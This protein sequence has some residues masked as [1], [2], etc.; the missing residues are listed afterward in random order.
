MFEGQPM[1]VIL[2]ATLLPFKDEIITD[3]LINGS[4]VTVGPGI[5]QEL[6]DTYMN[7]KNAG[8]IKKTLG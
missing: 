7:A 5:R 6:K 1:P 4:R 8:R 3:G 2:T